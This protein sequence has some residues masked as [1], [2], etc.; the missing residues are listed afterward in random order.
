MNS[1]YV[2]GQGMLHSIA[3]GGKSMIL[4]KPTPQTITSQG[5]V[6]LR[7][8]SDTETHSQVTAS[9]VRKA[10]CKSISVARKIDLSTR[11]SIRSLVSFR[12]RVSFMCSP[13]S[14]SQDVTMSVWEQ[15]AV[16]TAASLHFQPLRH[17][18]ET[19]LREV[20]LGSG[21]SGLCPWSVLP[22]VLQWGPCSTHGRYVQPG[23]SSGCKSKQ[24]K[25]F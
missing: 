24:K 10:T 21:C 22:D 11:L 15:A 2:L 5:K 7:L 9:A 8:L 16:P 3:K 1:G 19:G 17:L 6:F 20:N 23:L 18:L 12:G 13:P 25:F 14:L 4:P